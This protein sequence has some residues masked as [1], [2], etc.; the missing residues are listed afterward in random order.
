MPPTVTTAILLAPSVTNVVKVGAITNVAQ[1]IKAAPGSVRAI[2][3]DAVA[4]PAED[5]TVRLYD[6]AAPV[7]GVD[8][9]RIFV[10]CKAGTQIE[11]QW[12]SPK[13]FAVQIQ[14]ACVTENGGEAGATPPT[15]TVNV[16]VTWS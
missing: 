2:R 9:A 5:V 8:A 12:T 13:A 10:I 15:G 11:Y 3:I 1:V 14:V 7:V 16:Y 4:N 6:A